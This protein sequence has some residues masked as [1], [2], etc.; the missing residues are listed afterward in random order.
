M[1]GPY[2]LIVMDHF[3]NDQVM[4]EMRI[5]IGRGRGNIR[6]EGERAFIVSADPDRLRRALPKQAKIYDHRLS[7][8][9]FHKLIAGRP[10]LAPLAK[11][12]QSAFTEQ[13]IEQRA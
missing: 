4:H 12:W 5:F 7:E 8:K 3:V 2:L 9:Q 6:E 13:P 10:G 11:R 1:I